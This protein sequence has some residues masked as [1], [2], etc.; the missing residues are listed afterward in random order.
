MC[1]SVAPEDPAIIKLHSLQCFVGGVDVVEE[2]EE[3]IRELNVE[4]GKMMA[5][6]LYSIPETTN[7]KGDLINAE[8]GIGAHTMIKEAALMNKMLASS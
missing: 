4:P 2:G 5:L 3:V 8:R 7:L 6:H 1:I